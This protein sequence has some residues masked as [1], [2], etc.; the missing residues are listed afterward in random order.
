MLIDFIKI[1]NEVLSKEI[2]NLLITDVNYRSSEGTNI[3]NVHFYD[4]DF[5]IKGF[6]FA[7]YTVPNPLKKVDNDLTI[8]F[9]N[10]LENYVKPILKNE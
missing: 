9:T 6:Q 4:I 5:K 2:P 7:Y 1:T 3:I 10:Y 8:E